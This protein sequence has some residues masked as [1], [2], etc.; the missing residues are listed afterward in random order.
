[1]LREEFWPRGW[2]DATEGACCS[3]SLL[4]K[5]PWLPLMKEAYP[6]RPKPPLPKLLPPTFPS[7]LG[8]GEKAFAYMPCI[9]IGACGI[10]CCM[11]KEV[12]DHILPLLKELS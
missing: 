3:Q 5:K 7:W 11:F 10:G 2:L 6:P 12:L 1:M 9:N 4:L 8:I